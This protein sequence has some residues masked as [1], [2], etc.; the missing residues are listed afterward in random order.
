MNPNIDAAIAAERASADPNDPNVF[1]LKDMD[2]D[3][4]ALKVILTDYIFRISVMHSADHWGF[5]QVP[6]NVSPMVSRVPYSR[7]GYINDKRQPY[8]RWDDIK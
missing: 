8:S 3:P 7:T 1:L 6:C 4:R 2:T 5:M